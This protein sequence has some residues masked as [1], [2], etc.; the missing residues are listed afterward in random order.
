MTRAARLAVPTAAVLLLVSLPL[1]ANSGVVFLAG[2][3]MTSAV[4]ALSWNLLF[5]Y[6]GLASFGS[7]G[8]F[9]IGAYVS[10]VL[11]RE[12]YGS[13]FLLV[14]VL[15]GL[16]GAAVSWLVGCVALRRSKGIHLAILTL[17]LAELL[18]I[19][20]S[21][22]RWLGSEDGLP[23]IPRPTLPFGFVSVD[24]AAGN[25]YYWFL[26]AAC[27]VLTAALWWIAHG[28]FGRVL[29]SIRQDPERAAFIGIDVHACR[30]GAFTLSGGFGAAVGALYAP[31]SQIVTPDLGS[32]MHST[33]PILFTLIGGATS[34]WGPMI[35]AAAFAVIDFGT[36]TLVGM[37]EIVTGSILLA[38]VLFAPHGLA[39]AWRRLAGA[40][41]RP[42]PNGNTAAGGA[43][44]RPAMREGAW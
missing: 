27:G 36:R 22:T 17:A 11:L 32:M 12:G 21:H 16:V 5:G 1:W 37:S 31:W 9:S 30:L 10:A 28:R 40:R 3:T 39:G 38:I 23:N 35:G 6:T 43:I 15:A 44:G 18:R 41:V 2:V 8:F 25:N 24:L 14:V 34:F 33:Q 29:R 4:F 20:L 42:N 26:C 7:A 19:T 13:L